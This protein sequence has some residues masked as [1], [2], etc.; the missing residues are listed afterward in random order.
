M[1]AVLIPV[2]EFAAAKSR[3]APHFSAGARAGLAESMCED[4][5]DT[6]A[7]AAGFNTVFVASSEPRALFLARARG[8]EAIAEKRQVSESRS[9]D[10]ASRACAKRGV[11]A[12]LRLPADIPL[13]EPGDVTALFEAAGPAPFAVIVPSRDGT[14]TNALL[15]S[16]PALFPSH[17][18]PES[19]HKHVTEAAH[20][21]AKTR[22]FHNPRI[23]VDVDTLEDLAE[24]RGQLRPESA[25]ARWLA[26]F[27]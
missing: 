27:T 1:R 14:G 11:T 13:L 7:R 19:F 12:L 22:V 6:V 17:F 26:K 9:V 4:C 2:K 10:A 16:P 3:L 8:W 24:L 25:T 15:R 20:S 23:A 18:G 21:G 5:F